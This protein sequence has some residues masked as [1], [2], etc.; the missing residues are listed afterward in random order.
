MSF[1][2]ACLP[3]LSALAVDGSRRRSRIPVKRAALLVLLALPAVAEA[4]NAPKDRWEVTQSMTVPGRVLPPSTR[5][6]CLDRGVEEQGPPGLQE[7]QCQVLDTQRQGAT[8]RWTLQCPEG[9]GTFELTREGPDAYSGRVEMVQGGQTLQ[10]A[11][12]GRR[13]GVCAAELPEPMAPWQAAAAAAQGQAHAALLQACGQAVLNLQPALFRQPGL[14][15]AEQQAGFCTRARTP[16][17]LR[18]LA[19]RPRQPGV[20]GADDLGDASA[21]CGV[22]LG[23]QR[24]TL[25]AEAERAEDLKTLAQA[26]VGE[27]GHGQ[28]LVQREC[29]GRGDSLPVAEKYREFCAAHAAAGALPVA[30]AEPAAPAAPAKRDKAAERRALLEEALQR[31]KDALRGLAR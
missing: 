30:A 1:H 2:S 15:S 18:A 21:V 16:E 22:D 3:A 8:T 12:S 9:R 28:K 17:G 19:G 23:V 10:M 6:L 29:V 14:C 11:L 27:G 24:Q 7:H 5:T 31:G 20:P 26:C 13:L 4:A 25:C